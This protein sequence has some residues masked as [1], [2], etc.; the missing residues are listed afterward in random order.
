VVIGKYICEGTDTFL[1]YPALTVLG[2]IG[3]LVSSQIA[4]MIEARS[5]AFSMQAFVEIMYLSYADL[6]VSVAVTAVLIA[7]INTVRKDTDRNAV[8]YGLRRFPSLFGG[9]VLALLLVISGLAMFIIPGIYIGLRLVL[10]PY[11]VMVADESVLTALGSSWDMTGGKLVH[12]VGVVL[13]VAIIGAASI[14][15]LSLA[16]QAF[17]RE[18]TLLHVTFFTPWST[19]VFYQLHEAIREDSGQA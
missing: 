1:S 15:V 8:T 6:L 9:S 7:F 13:A 2:L 10:F 4:A 5:G 18:M 17:S 19:A 11:R 3:G 16:P 14:A 12:I